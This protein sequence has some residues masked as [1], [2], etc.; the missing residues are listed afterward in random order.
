MSINSITGTGRVSPAA[1]GMPAPAAPAPVRASA[2]ALKPELDAVTHQPVPPRFPWLSR[3]TQQ[4]G[5]AAKQ[6]PGFSEAPILGEN[7][8]RAA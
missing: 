2:T 6:P 8:D 7:L 3:L 5:H 1:A 4:L